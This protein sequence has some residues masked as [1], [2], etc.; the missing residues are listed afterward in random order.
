MPRPSSHGLLAVATVALLVAGLAA[1]A[2]ADR[3]AGADD[4]TQGGFIG[5][6]NWLNGVMFKQDNEVRMAARN[7]PASCFCT[8]GACMDARMHAH[9]R[10]TLMDLVCAHV[11]AHV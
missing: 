9:L 11:H 8:Q 10:C 4:N 2:K 7:W 5:A 6:K 1:P 3:P